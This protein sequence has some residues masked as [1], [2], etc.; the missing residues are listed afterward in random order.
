MRCVVVTVRGVEI[1]R[2]LGIGWKR[3]QVPHLQ[4]EHNLIRRERK[5]LPY[6][7]PLHV[8]RC[9]AIGSL[10]AVANRGGPD[11]SGESLHAVVAIGRVGDLVPSI[12]AAMT[13]VVSDDRIELL[14]PNADFDEQGAAQYALHL[15][16]VLAAELGDP[17]LEV[18]ALPLQNDAEVDLA[19]RGWNQTAEPV[20]PSFFH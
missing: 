3:R 1:N 5:R 12:A 2:P 19:L 20:P 4:S 18:G 13:L 9:G 16:R 10:V 6:C 15:G 14:M 17:G 8:V 7:Q 11:H